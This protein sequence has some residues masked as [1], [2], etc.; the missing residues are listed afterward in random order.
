MKIKNS[1]LINWEIMYDPDTTAPT[2]VSLRP[3]LAVV[4]RCRHSSKRFT[5]H[6][7]SAS[8]PG[9]VQTVLVSV[10]KI[11]VFVDNK[12][13]EGAYGVL[14]IWT[15]PSGICS[16]NRQAAAT[17]IYHD[18]EP[19]NFLPLCEKAR[20]FSATTATCPGNSWDSD[21]KW[22]DRGAIL[23]ASSLG[24]RPFRENSSISDTSPTS[25]ES[26]RSSSSD[27]NNEIKNLYIYNLLY[28]II[29]YNLIVYNYTLR[30][31]SGWAN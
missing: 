26:F 15:T 24:S 17:T 9:L 12:S 1:L 29:Y 8:P 7:R 31:I 11:V 4:R 22:R 2:W 3:L 18:A 5:L 10:N 19:W 13:R 20:V 21:R 16:L 28:I 30:K 23:R 25:H 27:R 6:P 14:F